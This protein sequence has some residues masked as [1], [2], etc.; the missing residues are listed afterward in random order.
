MRIPTLEIVPQPSFANAESKDAG[1]SLI[2]WGFGSSAL[3][4]ANMNDADP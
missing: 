3:G 4:L 1:T 2:Y